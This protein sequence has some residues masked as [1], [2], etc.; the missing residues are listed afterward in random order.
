VNWK[1]R[2][3]SFLIAIEMTSCA[4]GNIKLETD[5][6]FDAV[7]NNLPL[8]VGL[9]N[10]ELTIKDKKTGQ[11]MV[12]P[13]REVIELL[14]KAVQ[15]R[16]KPKERFFL[17]RDQRGDF[18]AKLLEEKEDVLVV[19]WL[20]LAE[21]GKSYIP[22]LKYDVAKSSVAEEVEF[23]VRSAGRYAYKGVFP[24]EEREGKF[25]AINGPNK[26][27]Y[28]AV[29]EETETIYRVCM[30]ELDAAKVFYVLAGLDEVEKRFVINN[31]VE[32]DEV[33]PN[34]FMLKNPVQHVLF[35]APQVPASIE[36]DLSDDILPMRQEPQVPVM[37][38]FPADVV[39]PET[40]ISDELMD[41]TL[42]LPA[43]PPTPMKETSRSRDSSPKRT[44]SPEQSKDVDL[45]LKHLSRI[46][47]SRPSDTF[48]ESV[49]S[50]VES[51]R[52]PVREEDLP[53]T[54]PI[55]EKAIVA[56][57]GTNNKV[58]FYRIVDEVQPTG[59]RL[60]CFWGTNTYYTK[61][62][63]IVERLDR[64][65]ILHRDIHFKERQDNGFFS[66]NREDI[67]ECRQRLQLSKEEAK[68]VKEKKGI[69]SVNETSPG[70]I[71]AIWG[72]FD[73]PLYYKIVQ[74][75]PLLGQYLFFWAGQ[76]YYDGGTPC[77][78]PIDYETIVYFNVPH[79]VANGKYLIK[80]N[81]RDQ[82][83]RLVRKSQR[84]MNNK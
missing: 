37:S 78:E 12:V 46:P 79:T 66:L 26:V 76:R 74:E 38:S 3:R 32:L 58:I 75:E 40:T 27:Y 44:P 42:K 39:I 53:V 33:S 47:A 1:Y 48:V 21:N 25:I 80:K 59:E 13:S 71:V 67:D 5:K 56:V 28:A 50:W 8:A 24:I 61:H 30:L 73:T 83:E 55:A 51:T 29:L 69:D 81:T 82:A 18:Y 49:A 4:F 54:R 52:V 68:K 16:I 31:N 7:I 57:W 14:A 6:S 60:F 10:F 34:R 62:P 70:S 17:I 36:K 84:N 22:G 45:Q 11:T 19:Q 64:R 23:T 20:R 15:E 77:I 9:L 2:A 35:P 43:L 72:K 41:P 63:A 65:T